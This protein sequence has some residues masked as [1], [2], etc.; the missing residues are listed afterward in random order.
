MV[1]NYVMAA[2]KGAFPL[3]PKHHFLQH[4][5]VQAD[6][7]RIK[8]WQYWWLALTWSI[9]KLRNNIVFSNAIF[10]ANKLFED[11]K[12]HK[13]KKNIYNPQK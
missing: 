6:G 1:E 4:I 9:W 7:V 10:N 2:H 8:R 12:T 11:A 13:E 5:G 3:S